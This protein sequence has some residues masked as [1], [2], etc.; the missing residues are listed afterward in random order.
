MLAVFAYYYDRRSRAIVTF[1]AFEEK[2][3]VTP[4]RTLIA[5]AEAGLIHGADRA[6]QACP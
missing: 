1:T 4:V 3:P 5:S 2:P 6:R